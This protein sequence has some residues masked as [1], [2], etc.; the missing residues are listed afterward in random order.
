LHS[1]GSHLN[2]PGT[3]NNTRRHRSAS[4]PSIQSLCFGWR[5]YDGGSSSDHELH[6]TPFQA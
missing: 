2:Y 5:K 4:R 3:P 1:V 6:H